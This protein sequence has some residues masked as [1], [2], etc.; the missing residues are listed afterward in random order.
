VVTKRT[1]TCRPRWDLRQHHG[2]DFHGDTASRKRQSEL[3]QSCG[4]HRPLA[5]RQ[6]NK[7]LLQTL[8]VDSHF[9]EQQR[10][11]FTTVPNDLAIV[12]I[13]EELPTGAGLVRSLALL[14]GHK[15][16]ALDTNKCH[17]IDPEASASYD[18]F[19]VARNSIRANHLDMAKFA[20]RNEGYKRTLSH[21]QDILDDKFPK[22]N[23]GASLLF[24]LFICEWPISNS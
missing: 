1:E 23:Q 18:G 21:I 3:R 13:R 7:P 4:K 8:R 2:G 12:C 9:L 17:Q 15:N 6:P 11:S 24:I 19:N 16:L 22:F 20:T 5:F 14:F 10:D